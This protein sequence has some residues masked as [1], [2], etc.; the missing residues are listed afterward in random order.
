MTISDVS[1]RRFLVTAADDTALAVLNPTALLSAQG[2]FEMLSSRSTGND[3]ALMIALKN[4]KA[5]RAFSGKPL[6]KR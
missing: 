3:D 2:K 5:T 4:R 6:P 1:R